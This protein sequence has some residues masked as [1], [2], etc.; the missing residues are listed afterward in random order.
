ML[1]GR[2]S[3]A[4]VQGRLSYF[5]QTKWHNIISSDLLNRYSVLNDKFIDHGE[6]EDWTSM[7]T[8]PSGF[9]RSGLNKPRGWNCRL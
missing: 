5:S 6:Y 9:E 7:V 2:F 3:H 8:G 1:L 4:N